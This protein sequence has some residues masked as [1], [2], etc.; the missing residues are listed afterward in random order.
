[1]KNNNPNND[2]LSRLKRGDQVAFEIIFHKYNEKLSCFVNNNIPDRED[3]ESI[4]QDVFVK[5][6]TRRDKIDTTKSLD[7][8]LFTITK[9]HIYSTLR[10]VLVK[11][12]YVE[13]L[14][15]LT[16]NTNIKPTDE[17]LEFSELQRLINKLIKRLPERRREIFILS[18]NMNM[19]Y[20]EIARFLEISENTVD[21]QM[22]K[23]LMFLKNKLKERLR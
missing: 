18:R 15:Y 9:N 4:V 10:K 16:N 13:E 23:S 17:N 19:T 5:L 2:L 1:M 21:T 11:R 7:A 20:K 3:A 22:R 8:Y 14:Y 12:K 6:W